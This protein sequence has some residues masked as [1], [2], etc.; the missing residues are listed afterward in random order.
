MTTSFVPSLFTRKTARWAKVSIGA[1]IL[2]MLT[3]ALGIG[4]NI[5]VVWINTDQMPSV[6]PP[7]FTQ[8]PER[9]TDTA[10]AKLVFLADVHEM[11]IMENPPTLPARLYHRAVDFLTGD[12]GPGF[13]AYSIGDLLI[14][15][16]RSPLVPVTI[17]YVI[18]TVVMTRL[19][20]AQGHHFFAEWR[21]NPAIPRSR[22]IALDIAIVVTLIIVT[23]DIAYWCW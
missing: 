7:A 11:H 15:I 19:A 18:F 4:A 14:W 17:V 12:D 10:Q 2:T 1:L 6:I 20:Y 3:I 22:R 21:H 13:Y 16:G 5:L 8:A 23:I 9:Y